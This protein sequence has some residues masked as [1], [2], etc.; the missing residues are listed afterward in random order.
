[1]TPALKKIGR[2]H[3]TIFDLQTLQEATEHFSEKNK[4]GEGGFGAVYKVRIGATKLR[5]GKFL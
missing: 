1:M 5:G 2:A 3:C 4:L